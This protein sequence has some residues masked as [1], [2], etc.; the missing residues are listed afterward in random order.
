MEYQKEFAAAR[1]AEQLKKDT[2]TIDQYL[3]E[4][5]IEALKTES[6]IRYVITQAG[7]GENGTAGQTAMVNYSGYLLDGQYFDSSVKSVAEEKGLY[8]PARSYQPYEVTIDQTSVIK[9][10]HEALMLMNKGAKA[11]VYIPSTL[12]YGPQ[13]RSAVIKP[14]SILV[15]D[16]EVVD[17]K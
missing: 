2:A 4:K 3:S 5:K 16:L 14:N 15:F 9:G 8:N 13:Q 10:W 12:A 11:T 6:G 1:E 17:L 7:V